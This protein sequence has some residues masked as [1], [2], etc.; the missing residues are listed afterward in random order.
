MRLEAWIIDETDC[1]RLDF[2]EKMEKRFRSTASDMGA[3][4]KRRSN[5]RSVYS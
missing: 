3:V 2:F 1:F 5:L 4:L